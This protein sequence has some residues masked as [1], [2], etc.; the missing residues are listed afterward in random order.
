MRST[1]IHASSAVAATAFGGAVGHVQSVHRAVAER[2]MGRRAPVVRQ[3]HDAI[4]DGVYAAVSIIGR[5]ALRGAGAAAAVVRPAAAPA[6]SESRGGQ[7]ALGAL[8]G[9]FGERFADDRSPLALRMTLRHGD[10][11][12][13]PTPA[14]L[15]RA[16][17]LSSGRVAVLIHGLCCTDRAWRLPV[18]R[19]GEPAEPDDVLDYGA[20]L[21]RDLGY[22]VLALRY[23]SGRRVPANGAE[24]ANLLEQLVAAWPGGV[25]ELVL[26]GHSM[27]GL[28]ARSA[29]AEALA[30]GHA[31][32]RPL[33]H[34]VMLG[35]PQLGSNLERAAATGQWAA[36]LLPET[37]PI[38]DL[39][40]L[41]SDGVLDMRDGALLHDDVPLAVDRW[42][43]GE[44]GGV[45]P[46]LPGVRHHTV[47]A[48][49]ARNPDGW[50][51]RTVLGD[52]LV[53]PTSAASRARGERR[54]TLAAED[55]VV[56]GGM[57]HLQLLHD[58]RV[59]AHLRRWLR[60]APAL[61]AADAT[62][63]GALDG[64]A[65]ELPPL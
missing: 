14:D 43:W 15:A 36:G 50:L 10:A 60:P 1:E 7:L 41:R 26:I 18:R 12:L 55:V 9:A 56:I 30:A 46:L 20:L 65:V 24:L 4:A 45:V 62:G 13:A 6:I 22:D 64:E 16:F 29:G 58:P 34:V 42:P 33:R 63:D 2:A 51:A 27:G 48:T 37:R 11:D 28:V 49:V 53:T 57:D 35:S 38:A 59:Y 44:R 21:R 8:N 5:L 54:L 32:L 39:L 23:N 25:R 3:T 47:A 40:G 17:P 61:P 19:G 52:W 31:W